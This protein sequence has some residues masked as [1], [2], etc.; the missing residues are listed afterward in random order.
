MMLL[1]RLAIAVM[2]AAAATAGGRSQSATQAAQ[3]NQDAQAAPIA[4]DAQA[5]QDAQPPK[6]DTP[7]APPAPPADP[8][9]L[10]LQKDTAHLLELVQDLKAEVDKAGSNTLSIEALR[11]ADAIQKL[12]KD[13][14]DRMK[15]RQGTVSRP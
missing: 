9:Q 3:A 6:E 15:E 14:K 1:E 8:A 2:L 7:P 11:K 4:Q 13:L 10:Q 5:A 12:A